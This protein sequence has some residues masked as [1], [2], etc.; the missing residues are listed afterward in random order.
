MGGRRADDKDMRRLFSIGPWLM[1]LINPP[2]RSSLSLLQKGCRV[3][4]VTVTL[5]T[6]CVIFAL[7]ASLG[8]FAWQRSREALLGIPQFRNT[9]TILIASVA[10][11]AACI[12]VLL[13]I[14]RI[15]R[16][17]IPK[18]PGEVELPLPP[19][20]KPARR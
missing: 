2:P 7:L 4:L 8:C 15:D 19:P 18:P 1:D 6:L 5:I 17:L 14:K 13:Q 3:L 16:K 10:V 9:V 12:M 20:A 11:N